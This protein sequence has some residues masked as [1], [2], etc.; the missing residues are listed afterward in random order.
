MSR[1]LIR[2]GCDCISASGEFKMMMSDS[3]TDQRYVWLLKRVINES[4]RFSIRTFI[5]TDTIVKIQ[6][7][8]N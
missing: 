7:N 4:N 6:N 2:H 8:M 3:Q 5:L 1:F